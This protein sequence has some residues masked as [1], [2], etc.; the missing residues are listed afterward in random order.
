M[1]GIGGKP[2]LWHIMSQYWAKGFNDFVIALG[3]KGESIKEYFLNY[4]NLQSDLK[5]SLKTGNVV[6][7]KK[8]YRDW[9]VNL[10]D[11]GVNTMTGGRLK[12][13][14]GRLK[15]TF[16]LTYGD[17]VSNV[18]IDRL[19]RFHRSHGKLVTVTAV[20]PSA[21]FGGM[22]FDE[23][24]VISFTE[25]PQEGEGWINGGYF[26]MEPQ[27]FEYISDD[28]SVLERAPLEKLAKEGRLM[29][30]KHDGFWQCMDTLRDKQLL[31]ELWINGMAPWKTWKESYE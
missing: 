20:K 2:I 12:R 31:E 7:D 28:E 15:E 21:R 14:A 13:L 19:L 29:A 1:V 11:T 23:D 27:V 25:K 18:D 3:Y 30:Y 24:R 9:A 22:R 5:I 8:C 6:A 16:M 10:V 4:Y 26:V 17:G